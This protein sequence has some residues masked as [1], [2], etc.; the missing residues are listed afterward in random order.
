MVNQLRDRRRG[1]VEWN[2][3]AEPVRHMP[4]YQYYVYVLARDASRYRHWKV[5]DSVRPPLAM[6][7]IVTDTRTTIAC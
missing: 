6:P 4:S 3:G 5:L 7:L 1:T 2:G